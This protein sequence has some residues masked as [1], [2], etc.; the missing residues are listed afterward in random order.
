MHAPQA[1]W[2]VSTAAP[3]AASPAT[4]KGTPLTTPTSPRSPLSPRSRVDASRIGALPGATGTAAA[5]HPQAAAAVPA[6]HRTTLPVLLS[7]YA[8]AG[9]RALRTRRTSKKRKRRAKMRAAVPSAVLFRWLWR[10][11]VAWLVYEW[12]WVGAP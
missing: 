7:V 2:R 8:K 11:C 6:T 10:A 5:A 9:V 4:P 3:G 12:L 1:L